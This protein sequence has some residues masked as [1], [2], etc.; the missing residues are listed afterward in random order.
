MRSESWLGFLLGVLILGA[1]FFTRRVLLPKWAV[2]LRR[3]LMA[4]DIPEPR[5][6]L[7]AH[8]FVLHSYTSFW[9]A[10][11]AIT[12]LAVRP[13]FGMNFEGVLLE[14][15]YLG[16]LL[17][18]LCVIA[19]TSF[20]FTEKNLLLQV[21]G[22]R[23]RGKL[24]TLNELGVS[25]SRM[26]MAIVMSLFLFGFL[27]YVFTQEILRI[28]PFLFLSVAAMVV[29]WRRLVRSIDAMSS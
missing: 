21:E 28:V 3:R 4:R 27:A 15:A 24:V 7:Q 19:V 22:A 2:R 8:L 13:D 17:I 12:L 16:L 11:T 10:V 20:L 26:S 29:H 9:V 23:R 18:S 14:V 6:N 1:A 25:T 5:A